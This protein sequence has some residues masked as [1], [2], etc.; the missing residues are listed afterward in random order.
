[1]AALRDAQTACYLTY[2]SPPASLWREM[3]Q[4]NAFAVTNPATPPE[5]GTPPAS[6]AYRQALLLALADP[7]QMSHDEIIH[8]RLYL[9]E[10]AGLA[11]LLGAVPAGTQHGFAIRTDGDT[12]PSHLAT[13]NDG[14]LWLDTE[15]LCRHLHDVG[16]RLRNGEA[17]QRIGLPPAMQA[18][19]SLTLIKR[20][21]KLWSAGVQRAFKR[22]AT[23]GSTVL[24]MAGVS[25]IHRM[26]EQGPQ[27]AKPDTQETDSLPIHGVGMKLAAPAALSATR[28]Q[29]S[30][31]SASGLAL[32]AVPDAPLN[33]KVGDPLALRAD[34]TAAWSL[35][36]IRW[37]RMRDARQVEL[38]VERL[39]P[40]IQPVWVHTLRGKQKTNPEPALFVPGLPALKQ[41]DRLLL[42]RGL[43]QAGM[44]AEVWQA[45]RRYTLTF[46]RRVEHTP[47]FDLIEFTL[48]EDERA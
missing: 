30:N 26:L 6:I 28:W 42:P 11:Q 27:A 4:L 48:F 1:M 9:G 2:T 12:P 17:P 29:V 47:S 5:D 37:V 31:D 16:V 39:S 21:L 15:A 23:P 33:L 35:A 34:E 22:H 7:P 40:Q 24:A 20:L 38:G 46:G 14:S 13:R 32:A 3:H 25:A 18:S 8:T 19:L 45:P 43:Y 41:P 36:V 10:F 44:D